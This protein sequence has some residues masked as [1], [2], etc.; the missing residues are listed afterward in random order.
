MPPQPGE[1]AGTVRVRP[2]DGQHEKAELAAAIGAAIL[3]TAPPTL[4]GHPTPLQLVAHTAQAETAVRDLLRQSIAT[5]RAE[6]QSWAAIG[7]ELGMSRQAVQQRFG[8]S[9]TDASPAASGEERWL[10][11]VTAFDEMRELELAGQLGWHTVEAGM[12]R[13][14]VVRT[15]T[16]WEHKRIVWSRSLGR[17]E[18]D[19]WVIGARAFPWI[20][21]V[22]DTGLPAAQ[23]LSG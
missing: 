6:G 22:R 18:D 13:H 19:G 8:A 21:L 3:D 20:Y 12:L 4:D 16:Q 2:E 15:A 5:A 11:P 1:E 9:A 14:R 7:A 23:E 10:G 17:Y